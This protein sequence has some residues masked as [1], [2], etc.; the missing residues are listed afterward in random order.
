MVGSHDGYAAAFGIVHRRSLTL[1]AD[2]TRLD[3]LDRLE[4]AEGKR[5]VPGPIP[6][7]L[8]FHIHPAFKARVSTDGS[9]ARL[10]AAD[11][12]TWLFESEGEVIVEP[13]ILFASPGGPRTATQIKVQAEYGAHPE[14]A[15]SF[16]R[17]ATG[18]GR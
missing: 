4:E 13:S 6:Y 10:D 2:G 7:A 11:G 8:R 17:I 15:W 12:E 3:G 16:R 18:A 9:A 14:I 1:A 5:A